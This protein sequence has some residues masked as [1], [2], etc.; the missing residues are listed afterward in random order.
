MDENP[1]FSSWWVLLLEW[2]SQQRLVDEHDKWTGIPSLYTCNSPMRALES[3]KAKD[4]S[5]EFENR[6]LI[7]SF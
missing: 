7:V 3:R 1:K 6:T 4:S 5:T 2:S